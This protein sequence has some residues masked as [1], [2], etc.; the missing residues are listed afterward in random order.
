[1]ALAVVTA[2]TVA[3]L[4]AGETQGPACDA[5]RGKGRIGGADGADMSTMSDDDLA[6]V[7]D[8]ARTA[9]MWSVRVDV[10]WSRVEPVQGRRD[11]TDVDRV[12]RAVV[13]R[14]MCPLGLVTY[15][16]AWAA[17]PALHPTGT[18]FAPTD[19][20]LFAGF[21]AAAARRYRDEVRV[22]EV[23][24]EPNT[25]QFFQ[26]RPDPAAYGRLLAAT[27]GAVKAVDA[28]ITVV[29]GG[30]AP[31]EDD[32]GDIAPTTFLAG[33]YAGGFNAFFDAF[34]IHPYSYP[35]LP[36]APGTE[37][38]NTALRVAIMHEEMVAGGDA[39]KQIW[40]TECGAPTGTAA[41]AVS[42][43]VQ[44]QTL[45]IVLGYAKKTPWIGPAFVYSIRDGGSDAADAEQNFG[46]LRRDF[47]PKPAYAVVSAFGRGGP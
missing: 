32:G 29:S 25:V 7:L 30:L 10:D 40:I 21:A 38:W 18:H 35:A 42:E 45:D 22:W 44:A 24:N 8:A 41:V 20:R 26:P 43:D 17:D 12:M 11:W 16:P 33:L 14:G 19:P 27:H 2:V 37:A 46:V 28:H 6:R 15:A 39:G 5:A 4:F 23:W 31:A 3:L 13:A 34:A 47:S 1:M 9:G 36:N